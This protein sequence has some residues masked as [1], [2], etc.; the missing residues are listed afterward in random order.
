MMTGEA[1]VPLLPPPLIDPFMSKNRKQPRPQAA[2]RPRL[3]AALPSP[4]DGG[5]QQILRILG[6][7]KFD[8]ELVERRQVREH[9]TVEPLSVIPSPKHSRV[10]L[11]LLSA[12]LPT[13]ELHLLFPPLAN[14]QSRD[15]TT[16]LSASCGF[17]LPKR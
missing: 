3:E 16:A 7:S 9:F 8:R 2:V 14:L 4:Q 12:A 6:S 13:F 15:R 11:Y 5:L 10:P 17:V 1:F